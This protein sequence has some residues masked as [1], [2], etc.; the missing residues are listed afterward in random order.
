MAAGRTAGLLPPAAGLVLTGSN[1]AQVLLH[2][3]ASRAACAVYL[4]QL[5]AAFEDRGLQAGDAIRQL[6]ALSFKAG[7][8]LAHARLRN[9]KPKIGS[10]K[11]FILERAKR[12]F[13]HMLRRMFL[14]LL[15]AA[16]ECRHNCQ[17]GCYHLCCMLALLLT[18]FLDRHA[19]TDTCYLR[20]PCLP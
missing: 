12:T 14:G 11:L 19:N 4:V 18:D 13:R 20:F 2:V 3:D 6:L 10:A 9:R 16:A 5:L 17:K 7:H 15:L 8:V 1:P